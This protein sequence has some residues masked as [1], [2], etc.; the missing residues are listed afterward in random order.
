MTDKAENL[1]RI[2]N[3]RFLFDKIIKDNKNDFYKKV[4]EEFALKSSSVRVG[5]F[6]RFDIPERYKIQD[7]LIAFMQ[8]YI[9]NQK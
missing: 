1:E 9:V 7:N 3:I 8:N 2:D 6:T 4:A 5:W